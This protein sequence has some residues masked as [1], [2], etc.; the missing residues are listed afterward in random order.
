MNTL[1]RE[2]AFYYEN[3]LRVGFSGDYEEWLDSCLQSED[4]LSGIVLEL[5]TCGSD[6]NKTIS[7]LHNY[8]LE[9]QV[10]E[11]AVCDRLR[12]FFKDAYYSNRLTKEEITSAM[13]QLAH[14]NGAPFDST[15]DSWEDMYYLE[16]Y[17]SQ[18]KDG[19]ISWKSFDNAFFSYLDNGTPLDANSIWS[20]R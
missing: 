6:V 15:C 10:D 17:C 1:N 18:S 14:N 12:L 2:D 9:Q 4:P 8:C 7:V 20:R 19:Y 11:S 3:L 13:R 16:Y 5:S